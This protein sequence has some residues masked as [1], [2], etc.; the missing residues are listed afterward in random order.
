MTR[1]MIA[2]FLILAI[3]GISGCG[4]VMTATYSQLLD[5]TAAL[6]ARTSAAADANTLNE[7]GMKEALRK[8]AAVW[9]MFRDARDGKVSGN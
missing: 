6:S 1:K 9:Q 7:G 5:E 3:L 8:Q 2:V 4:V